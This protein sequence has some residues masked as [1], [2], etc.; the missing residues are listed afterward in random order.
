MH[1]KDNIE[2]IRYEQFGDDGDFNELEL[3]VETIEY[4]LYKDFKQDIPAYDLNGFLAHID[5]GHD[6]RYR[7]SKSRFTISLQLF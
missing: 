3:D 4:R 7:T 5:G 1:E 2:E 6:I